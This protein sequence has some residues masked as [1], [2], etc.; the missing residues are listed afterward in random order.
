MCKRIPIGWWAVLVLLAGGLKI[1]SLNPNRIEQQ[2]AHGI[3]LKIAQV[4][5]FIWGAVPI[6]VGD[7][8]YAGVTI[9]AICG[10]VKLIKQWRN[11]T[12]NK[13]R[14]R[15]LALRFLFFG[16]CTY[17]LFYGLWGLNY[18]RVGIAGQLHLDEKTACTKQD[19][20]TLVERLSTQLNRLAGQLLPTHRDSFNTHK[21]LF[22]QGE[23]LYK[24]A[25]IRYPFL[26][27]KHYSVKPSLYSYLGNYLG[28]QG[29]Y[30]PITGEAQVNTTVPISVQ[31]FVLAHEMAHQLGYAKESEANFVAFLACR[32]HP[33]THFKYSVYFDVYNYAVGALFYADSVKARW[34]QNRLHPK[35]K[36]DIAEYKAFYAKYK[37]PIEPY[38]DKMY[39]V[40]LKANNQPKGGE[41]YGEVVT[42]LIAYYKKY[43]LDAV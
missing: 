22:S 28:F 37:N 11:K 10:A 14:M 41:S 36:K 21:K 29:Y 38:I 17:V 15:A 1:F 40:F 12:L 6:S 16:L 9:W 27:Y 30:N 8:L 5:R 25:A 43:G 35:V 24:L 20:D 32:M 39:S 4:L 34:Y 7:L 3:Y 42:W 2:Y 26:N 13:S 19:V 31:P 23:Q 33:S 18:S